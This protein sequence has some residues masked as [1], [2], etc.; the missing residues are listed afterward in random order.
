MNLKISSQRQ[1]SLRRALRDTLYTSLGAAI[2]AV[3][4]M[5]ALALHDISASSVLKASPQPVIILEAADGQELGRKG[6]IRAAP[7]ARSEFPQFLVDAVIA[8]EDRRF[9]DHGGIDPRGI[10]RALIRNL[11]AGGVKE[12][13][14][15]ITQQLV[16][17]MNGEDERTVRR[18]FREALLALWIERKLSKDEILT[19]YLNNVYLGSGITGVSA[20]ARAY[21][22][23]PVRRLS[24]E[25]CALLAGIIKAPSALNPLRN[26]PEA[27][28]RAETVLDAMVADGRLDPARAETAKRRPANLNPGRLAALP[29]SWFADWAHEEAVKVAASGQ[30]TADMIRARTTLVPEL[31]KLAERV[32]SA[33]IARHGQQKGVQQ[34]ALVALR[35]DGAVVAMVGGKGYEE[36]E[37]N[38]AVQALRQPG[39]TFKL[40]VYLAALRNGYSLADNIEDTPVEID[41]WRPK[42]FDRGFHGRVT[43]SEAFI[44]SLNVA[45]VRLAQNIG[46]DQVIAAARDLGIDAPL[47]ATPSLALGSS[48][49]NLLDLTGAYAS[50][51]AGMRIEPW[52][53]AGIEG[54]GAVMPVNGA[55]R[56]QPDGKLAPYS[57]QLVE[58]LESAVRQGTGRRAA[59]DGFSAGKTGTTEDYRDAWFIGFNEQLVVGVW[60]GNDDNAPMRKVTGGDLPASIWKEFITKA[61]KLREFSP[62]AADDEQLMV[63]TIPPEPQNEAARGRMP[64]ETMISGGL[65]WS[66][67]S[68]ALQACDYEACGMAYR[69]FRASDCSYRPY[70]GGRRLCRLNEDS[71]HDDDDDYEDEQSVELVESGGDEE[72]FE[73]AYYEEPDMAEH[74]YCNFEACSRSYESFRASDC[75]YRAYSGRRKF[76]RK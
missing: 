66:T 37:F 43:L 65:G 46:I 13:G 51:R 17:V 52:G 50:V 9:Y 71:G 36:S 15:T 19:R 47:A 38:R 48:E 33:A 63:S 76:C 16:R 30:S 29:P 25:E 27:R 26:L 49:V 61:V 75:S 59:L 40:F 31:Q 18:K 32:T 54:N 69:S 1:S 39:S 20:A 12:G 22:D 56:G 58:L 4:L 53:I 41:G 34:V 23:K 73:D 2:A 24:L 60:V 57:A 68:H 21:F 3:A 14:S 42:N 10:A 62:P 5:I 70:S 8:T 6:P 67:G 74:G 11:R 72:D 7:V 55:L 28:Q 44:K 64:A 45:T 35:P